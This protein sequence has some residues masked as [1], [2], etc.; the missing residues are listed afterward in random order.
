MVRA[1][2][3]RLSAAT[4]EQLAAK[5]PRDDR[6]DPALTWAQQTDAYIAAGRPMTE[7]QLAGIRRVQWEL[8][9]LEEFAAFLALYQERFGK[10]PPPRAR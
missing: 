9:R 3:K 1:P 7:R 5:V 10:P 2:P 6:S 4:L 8:Y